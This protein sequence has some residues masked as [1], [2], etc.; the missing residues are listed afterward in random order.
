MKQSPEVNEYLRRVWTEENG[1]PIER[2]WVRRVQAY[3]SFAGIFIGAL[4]MLFGMMRRWPEVVIFST[5][6]II[7]SSIVL[8]GLMRSSSSDFF[9]WHEQIRQLICGVMRPSPV[10]FEQLCEEALCREA[11]VVLEAQVGMVMRMFDKIGHPF[12][13]EFDAIAGGRR[14]TLLTYELFLAA[15]IAGPIEKYLPPQ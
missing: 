2:M 6:L 14:Q 15:G 7:V 3:I 13:P 10:S 4:I 12:Q 5:I 8:L 11:S 9:R 1:D